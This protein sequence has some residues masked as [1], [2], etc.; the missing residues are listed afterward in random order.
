MEPLSD[1]SIGGAPVELR[2]SHLERSPAHTVAALTLCVAGC[3]SGRLAGG[4]LLSAA[5]IIRPSQ[6]WRSEDQ[7]IRTEFV[8]NR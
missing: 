1:R 5:T 3:V 4:P 2:K 6:H 8:W 7:S